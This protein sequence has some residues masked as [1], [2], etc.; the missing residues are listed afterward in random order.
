MNPEIGPP[1]A[2][3][4]WLAHARGDLA[5]AR[6]EIRDVP[7]SLRCFHAQ[8]TAEKS[9]KAVCLH[10]KVE[11]PYVHDLDRLLDVLSESGEPI[12]EGVR[13]ATVLTP[14]AVEARYPFVGDPITAEEL[15]RALSIA[16]SILRWAESAI[17]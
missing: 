12:P 3:E 9:I 16:T 1:D 15:E 7:R 2:P 13:E 8:Q 14:Y 5:M 4:S 6:A 11:F 17:R 10:R